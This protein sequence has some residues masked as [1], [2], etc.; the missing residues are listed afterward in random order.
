M[1]IYVKNL[2]FTSR[3][4]AV[5]TFATATFVIQQN[6]IWWKILKVSGYFIIIH[7]SKKLKISIFINN[8]VVSYIVRKNTVFMHPQPCFLDKMVVAA[9]GKYVNVSHNGGWL[10]F[11]IVNT[12]F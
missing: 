1:A 7:A 11:L 6:F 12:I 9:W 4:A 5:F 3:F 8:I 2:R 10:P